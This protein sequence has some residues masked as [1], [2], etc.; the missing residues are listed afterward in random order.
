MA[1]WKL[2][3]HFHLFQ[4]RQIFL[5]QKCT[6][7]NLFV[8]S[9]IIQLVFVTCPMNIFIFKWL[10]SEICGDCFVLSRSILILCYYKDNMRDDEVFCRRATTTED[11]TTERISNVTEN[12]NSRLIALIMS[13]WHSNVSVAVILCNNDRMSFKLNIAS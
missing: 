3:N 2:Q 13:F 9:I 11:K 10:L 8:I 12:L 6:I 1:Y 7:L 5:L 4:I